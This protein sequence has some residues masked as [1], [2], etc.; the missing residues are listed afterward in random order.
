[1]VTVVLDATLS[2]YVVPYAVHGIMG[3]VAGGAFGEKYV[4]RAG[5]LLDRDVERQTA[6][7][8]AG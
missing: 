6:D 1:M 2:G 8:E 4:R 5:R 7:E 3:L